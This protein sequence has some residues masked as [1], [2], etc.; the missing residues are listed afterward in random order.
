MYTKSVLLDLQVSLRMILQ[1]KWHTFYVNLYTLLSVNSSTIRH[2]L[3]IFGGHY[4][5]QIPYLNYDTYDYF[6]FT[7]QI[8]IYRCRSKFG[9]IL[10]DTVYISVFCVI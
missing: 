3:I 8:K 4:N 5:N 7:G 10:V 9:R 2:F 1:K 6:P